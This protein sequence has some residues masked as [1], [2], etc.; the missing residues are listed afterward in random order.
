[1]KKIMKILSCFVFAILLISGCSCNKED[2]KASL[3]I[4]DMNATTYKKINI[5]QYE[6]K[7]KNNEDFVLY[8]YADGCGGCAQFS[9]VLESV[10][11]EK[12]LI[13][14]GLDNNTIE[15]GHELDGRLTASVLVF[16]DGKIIAEISQANDEDKTHFNTKDN[17]IAF[18]EQYTHMPTM[19]YINKEQ[20]DVKI[21]SGEDF[22][23]YYASGGCADCNSIENRF[24]RNFLDKNYNSKKFYIVE[25][26]DAGMRVNDKGEPDAA[27][28]NKF[29][30]DYSLSKTDKEF[31]Y[32]EGYVPTFHYYKDGK[33]E[34]MSV[35][36]ND[37]KEE[38]SKNDNGTTTIKITDSFYDDNPY[39]ISGETM[40]NTDYEEKLHGF[41]CDKVQAFFDEYLPL[42][43]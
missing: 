21:S 14:Y 25:T 27:Q 16:N 15:D 32:G 12:N 2:K 22:I 35:Y 9:P 7:I 29:K 4:G 10:I 31:G 39:L 41:F 17:F 36:L 18:L 33:I 3:S 38:V 26:R 11:K 40:L 30:A 42:V 24:L 34:A 28:W 5:T 6:T 20:L 43:D 19:Y 23:V 1:M 8:L 13:V 37:K